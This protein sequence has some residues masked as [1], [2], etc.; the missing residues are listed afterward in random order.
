[1]S[2]T[3]KKQS[4]DPTSVRFGQRIPVEVK[5]RLSV[6]GQPMGYGTLRN[7]S[8]SGALIET[9]AD[10]PLC[11]NLVVTLTMRDGNT[12]ATRDFDAYVVR[13]EA[14]GLGVE[15]RD[16]AS[17]DITDLLARASNSRAAN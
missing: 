10:V 14:E 4:S 12:P 1:M 6:N 3:S 17:V 9:E 2:N 13:A 16:M 5:V 15:W 8:V 11:T 7:V